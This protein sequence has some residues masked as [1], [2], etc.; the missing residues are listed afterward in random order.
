MYLAECTPGVQGPQREI[1]RVQDVVKSQAIAHLGFD[2]C[3]ARL[4][5]SRDYRGSYIS[6]KAFSN[7]VGEV[8]RN[9]RREEKIKR[10]LE[11]LGMYPALDKKAHENDLCSGDLIELVNLPEYRDHGDILIPVFLAGVASDWDVI[12]PEIRRRFQIP[13][14]ETGSSVQ[15]HPPKK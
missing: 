11:V 5:G 9:F 12:I 3:H 13:I 1:S 7:C 8:C 2:N 6:Y 14:E 10:M 15:F 4:V